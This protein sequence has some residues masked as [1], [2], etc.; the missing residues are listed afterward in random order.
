[1]GLHG[2]DSTV[3]PRTSL[4]LGVICVVMHEEGFV[5]RDGRSFYKDLVLH[6]LWSRHFL[7]GWSLNG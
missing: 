6:S 7:T 2:I 5:T 1:M 4:H 3:L